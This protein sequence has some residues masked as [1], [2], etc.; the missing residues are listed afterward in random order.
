MSGL[1][2]NTLMRQDYFALRHAKS[3]ASTEAKVAASQ[4]LLAQR[5][6]LAQQLDLT[7]MNGLPV[8]DAALQI[9]SAIADHPVVIVAGETGSGKTTQLPKFCLQNGLGLTGSIGHTQ[10]R[11]IAARTVAQRIAQE[12]GAELGDARVLSSCSERGPPIRGE[13]EASTSVPRLEFCLVRRV[14]R[15]LGALRRQVHLP[16]HLIQNLP[17]DVR[18]DVL[19]KNRINMI[20]QVRLVLGRLLVAL[21]TDALALLAL[22][23]FLG[24]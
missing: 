13:H 16:Q 10:P 4:A 5:Q 9:R 19:L 23:A 14:P 15:P 8:S 7:P 24:I 22:L 1:D 18:P 3:G 17:T 12:V 6:R 2:Q 21:Q 20:T 11:R